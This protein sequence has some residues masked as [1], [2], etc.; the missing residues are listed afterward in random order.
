[1]A[2]LPAFSYTQTVQMLP[3]ICSSLGINPHCPIWS[4][5]HPW[6]SSPSLNSILCRPL[7]LTQFSSLLGPLSLVPLTILAP[8]GLRP[9]YLE[10]SQ[11]LLG[12]GL[13]S[14]PLLGSGLCLFP[15]PS[16]S[17]PVPPGPM[18][19][20]SLCPGYRHHYLKWTRPILGY[21]PLGPVYSCPSWSTG[22]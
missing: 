4:L 3:I 20:S 19:Q 8:S 18:P 11:L 6:P 2:F 22:P 7:N 5:T 17:F 14:Q 9:L 21:G 1:M 12:F 13:Q 16:N 15:G 10:Q